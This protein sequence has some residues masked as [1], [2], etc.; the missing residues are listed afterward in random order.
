MMPTRTPA[1]LRSE[2]A[3]HVIELPVGDALSPRG[4]RIS[5]A[6]TL[7]LLLS[8]LAL[9]SAS[10]STQLTGA[11]PRSSG[12]TTADAAD[13]GP[14]GRVPATGLG[15]GDGVVQ[16]H[17]DGP[18]THLDWTGASYTTAEASFVGE[19]VASPG[20]RVHRTLH[21]GNAGPSDALMTVSLVLDREPGT[22]QAAGD[23]GDAIELFWD[24]AGIA[25]DERFSTLL[26]SDEQRPVAAEARVPRGETVPVTVGFSMPAEV[27]GHTKAESD[28]VLAFQVVVRLQGDTVDPQLPALAVTGAQ[29]LGIIALA[30][31]LGLLGWLLVTV[32]RQRRVRCDDCDTPLS[33]GD[34]WNEQH[35]EDGTRT[36]QCEPCRQAWDGCGHAHASS[37]TPEPVAANPATSR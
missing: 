21:I 24:V 15:T 14:G 33:R 18:T 30:L 32:A 11:S 6:I 25:G 26:A 1:V 7:V 10:A 17:W 28:S 4:R 29:L 22:E 12:A 20:D 27:T 8:G 23:L 16:A 3:P 37:R 31:G 19:R 34:S 2:Q 36:V 35:A 5:W 13:G 9:L